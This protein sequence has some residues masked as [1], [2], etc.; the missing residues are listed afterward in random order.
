MVANSISEKTVQPEERKAYIYL[1][2]N[3]LFKV[4]S[5]NSRATSIISSGV[6]IVT[7]EHIS[8]LFLMPQL[9]KQVNVSWVVGFSE[10]NA[11]PPLK[12]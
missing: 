2:E 7:F 5:N 11:P 10:M 8:H 9:L 12:S 3:Y 6:F 1:A 4:N